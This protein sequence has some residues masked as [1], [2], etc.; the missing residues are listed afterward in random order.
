MGFEIVTVLGVE[1]L[2]SMIE[3]GVN[4][5]SGE[6]WDAWVNLNYRVAADPSIH[7]CVEHLLAIAVKP[8]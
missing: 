7:G 5:L 6:A 2:V 1:G 4:A 8:R 3:D